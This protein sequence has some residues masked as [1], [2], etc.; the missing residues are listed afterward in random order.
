MSCSVWMFLKKLDGNL[1]F[2][3]GE[4]HKQICC[5]FCICFLTI[6]AYLV[7]KPMVVEY[8]L[9]DVESLKF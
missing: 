7:K 5:L 1:A 9:V 6:A 4:Y 2:S 8:L 3:T